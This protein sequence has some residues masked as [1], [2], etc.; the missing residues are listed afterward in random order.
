MTGSVD[1]A[2]S[3]RWDPV[4]LRAGA[5]LAL[6]ISVPVTLVAAMADSD[7]T[8][9]NALFF[10]G[11]VLGFVL[12]SGCAAWI[13]RAGTPMSHAIVTASATYLAAQTVFVTIRL[14]GGNDINWF[15]VFF[16]LMLVV[17]AGLV[18]GLLGE[19][20]QR[21]GVVASVNRNRT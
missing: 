19:R 5:G 6:M 18:G 13:Q 9:V 14:A 8:G 4:A 15:R 2:L 3:S 20:L 11:A 17:M 7:S 12:G 16:T 10:F 1:S 21:R